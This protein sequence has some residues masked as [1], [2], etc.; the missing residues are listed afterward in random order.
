MSNNK[1]RIFPI[2]FQ[3]KDY[4]DFA[5]ILYIT[6]LPNKNQYKKGDFFFLTANYRECITYHR[7]VKFQVSNVFYKILRL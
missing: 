2:F 7:T 4:K 3:I 6:Q 1:I 5:I